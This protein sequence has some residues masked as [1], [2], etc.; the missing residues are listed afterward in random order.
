MLD[1]TFWVTFLWNVS[2]LLFY[3]GTFTCVL[4]WIWSC[5][6]NQISSNQI[7]SS[8]VILH[9][10]IKCTIIFTISL[11]V[12]SGCWLLQMQ[13]CGR[14]I[15][16]ASLQSV[17]GSFLP[18]K[19]VCWMLFADRSFMS[20]PGD[21]DAAYV[22]V[23]MIQILFYPMLKAVS[24]LSYTNWYKSLMAGVTISSLQIWRCQRG[25]CFS[26]WL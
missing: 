24:V 3:L 19:D 21:L 20:S 6:G 17:P 5:K 2:V 9:C 7:S 13:Q 10:K 11:F 4:N 12:C 8:D 25:G 15:P 23:W 26:I 18:W 22:P 16:S 14:T 1:A